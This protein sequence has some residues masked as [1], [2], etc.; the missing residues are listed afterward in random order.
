MT[1][2]DIKCILKIIFLIE[3]NNYVEGRE[4]KLFKTLVACQKCVRHT[5]TKIAEFAFGT[6]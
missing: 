1:F 5:Q 2:I 6:M 3:R 4:T